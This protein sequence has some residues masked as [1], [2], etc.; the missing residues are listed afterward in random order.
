M[1]VSPP[2]R[3]NTGVLAQMSVGLTNFKENLARTK[4]FLNSK[5]IE[6]KTDFEKN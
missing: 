4:S 2:V 6:P 1:Y 5:L 3:L